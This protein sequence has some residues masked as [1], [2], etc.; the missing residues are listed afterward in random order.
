MSEQSTTHDLLERVRTGLEDYGRGDF[1]GAMRF[2]TSD[3]VWDMTGGEAFVGTAAIRGF[4]EEFYRQF[5]SLV[6]EVE[7]VRD[8]GGEILLAVN[9]MRGR[10][11]GSAVEVRQRG[12][13]VIE[14]KAGFAT[15]L[16]AYSDTD[17]ALIAAERL[18]ESRA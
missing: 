13:F 15:R 6:V 9:T 8:F 12:G 3:A 4:F 7:E 1:D 16:T 10:P 17:Q 18:A 5:E 2:F 11:L 14:G